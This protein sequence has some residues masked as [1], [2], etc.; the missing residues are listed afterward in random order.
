MSHLIWTCSV[1]NCDYCTSAALR[2][3]GNRY[4]KQIF[5]FLVYLLKSLVVNHWNV[6]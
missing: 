3:T 5:T 6:M 1:G 2:V 4:Q